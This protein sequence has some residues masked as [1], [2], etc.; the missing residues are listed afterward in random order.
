MQVNGLEIKSAINLWKRIVTSQ[1][2]I[3]PNSGEIFPSSTL[4]IWM[5]F[6]SNFHYLDIR[7]AR[8]ISNE[9]FI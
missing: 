5:L 6:V 9:P 3:H 7:E 1:A 4:N 2:I 8:E